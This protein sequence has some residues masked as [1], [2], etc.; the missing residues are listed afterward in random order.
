M[1]R[2]KNTTAAESP[3]GYACTF[4]S[5]AAENGVKGSY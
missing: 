4:Y 1:K 5:I 3:R 2:G